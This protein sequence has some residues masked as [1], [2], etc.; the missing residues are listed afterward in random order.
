[1]STSKRGTKNVVK[2][3]FLDLVGFNQL[4]QCMHEMKDERG[5]GAGK[6]GRDPGSAG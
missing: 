5:Q 6:E 4:K 3:G 1:M 2:E